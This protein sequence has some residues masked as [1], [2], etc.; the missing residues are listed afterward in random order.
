M[1]QGT[2]RLCP[3]DTL[4]IGTVVAEAK[5]AALPC[6]PIDDPHGIFEWVTCRLAD[7]AIVKMQ[8]AGF[9]IADEVQNGYAVLRRRR[10]ILFDAC[11][12]TASSC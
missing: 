5:A 3:E 10:R 12:A 11:V 1:A 7:P 2:V 9:I 8:E 4:T 6:G